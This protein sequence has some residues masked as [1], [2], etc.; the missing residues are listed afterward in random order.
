MAPKR[1]TRST[2]APPTPNET[3][4]TV[5]EAQ[6]QA[7]IDQGV[8]AAMAE[9]EASRASSFT[10]IRD[11]RVTVSGSAGDSLTG[12]GD[13][14]AGAGYCIAGTA[15]TSMTWVIGTEWWSSKPTFQELASTLWLESFP[16]ESDKIESM[17]GGLPNMEPWKHL[18]LQSK[19]NAR[20]Y[21]NATEFEGTRE[22]IPKWRKEQAENKR[23][24][25]KPPSRR[26]IRI[27]NS[28]KQENP[29]TPEGVHQ[30]DH[31]I[32]TIWGPKTPML[33]NAITNQ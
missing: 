9:A 8:A 13:D 22:S 25:C 7:L 14:I 6:L 4:T 21:R 5:T 28:T 3:T 12:T 18:W 11:Y 31:L 10:D 19:D 20:G 1:A 26:T 29:D 27:N 23:N 15:G 30:L 33:Q 2:R 17:F 24:V 32:K 16:E